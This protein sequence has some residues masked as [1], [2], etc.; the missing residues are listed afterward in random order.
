MKINNADFIQ[1]VID[2]VKNKLPDVHIIIKDDFTIKMQRSDYWIDLF[3]GNLY[4]NYMYCPSYFKKEYLKRALQPFIED[5]LMGRSINAD[6]IIA[7]KKNIY[8]LL[9]NK[10]DVEEDFASSPLTSELHL[11]YVF[12]QGVRF[13]F[14]N[15]KILSHLKIDFTSLKNLAAKNFHRDF[16]KPLMLID[17]KRNILGYNYLDSYDSTRVLLLIK[18]FGGIEEFLGSDILIMIPTRDLLLLF[19][20][21]DIP[22]LNRIQM[23]GRSEYINN[24]YPISTTIY[25]LQA[26]NIIKFQDK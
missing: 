10:N 20:Y 8:P 22:S 23:L 24:S 1:L 26:G 2:M 12:D 17:K 9:V 18:K 6:D 3:L 5:L 15:N 13:F 4:Q 7:N 21:Q 19:S 14:I 16:D 11:V 25:K